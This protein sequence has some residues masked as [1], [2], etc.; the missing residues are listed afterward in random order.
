MI[1]ER[2]GKN[3]FTYR[4]QILCNKDRILLVFQ[5]GTPK[6]LWNPIDK[7]GTIAFFQGIVHSE[8]E[9]KERR[10]LCTCN[11][12][13]YLKR[14]IVYTPDCTF[15]SLFRLAVLVTLILTT[16]FWG[17]CTYITHTNINLTSK[18]TRLPEPNTEFIAMSFLNDICKWSHRTSGVCSE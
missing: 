13:K 18:T 8:K 2:E 5:Q 1:S 4:S 9:G 12:L 16:A 7:N 15:S 10:C 17:E 3:T 6:Y 14:D 11:V